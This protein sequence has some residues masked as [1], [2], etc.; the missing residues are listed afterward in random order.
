[1]IAEYERSKDIKHPRDVGDAREQILRKFL[2]ENGLVPRRYGVSDGKT[3]VSSP[4]GHISAEMDI[5]LFDRDNSINLMRRDGGYEVLPIESVYGVIQVKSRLNKNE[6][7][8]G[9]ENIASFKKLDKIEEPKAGFIIVD[10]NK[11]HRGFGILYAYDTDLEW[12]DIIQEIDAFA[13]R[14]RI[15]CGATA[16]IF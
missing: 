8:D 14:M 9:L 4:T 3:R 12:M 10:E 11:S 15:R 7:R 6:I 1:M 5:V 13:G 16:F 2:N